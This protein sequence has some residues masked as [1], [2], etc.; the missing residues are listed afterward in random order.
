MQTTTPPPTPAFTLE[1]LRHIQR[2]VTAAR[3]ELLEMIEIADLR[4]I[5]NVPRKYFVPEIGT[6]IPFP[7][8]HLSRMI[9]PVWRITDLDDPGRRAVREDI[10][11]NAQWFELVRRKIIP[12]RFR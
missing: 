5:W 4:A 3:H 7:N 11:L 2:E 9:H 8:G 6:R 12:E 10:L 1:E